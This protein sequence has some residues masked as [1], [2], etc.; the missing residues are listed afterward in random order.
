[1]HLDQE[2]F[3]DTVFNTFKNNSFLVEFYAD[4]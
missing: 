3:V 2:T 4:W 1:M